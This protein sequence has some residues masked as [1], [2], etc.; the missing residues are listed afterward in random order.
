MPRYGQS[1][2]TD[3]RKPGGPRPVWERGIRVKFHYTQ[4]DFAEL[5]LAEQAYRVSAQEGRAGHGLYVTSARPGS[6]SDKDLLS[7]LF[8]RPRPAL[9]VDGVVVLRDD[10]FSWE[11]YETRKYVYRTDPAAILDLSLVLVGVG[12]RRRGN[13][14]WSEGIYA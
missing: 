8:T 10:A 9:F 3:P 11:R 14:L 7:L 12:A 6:M 5:I 13:W 2:P 4:P 1:M